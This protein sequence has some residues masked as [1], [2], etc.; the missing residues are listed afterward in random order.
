VTRLRAAL[1]IA[2]AGALVIL[3]GMFGTAG[4]LSGLGAIALGTALSAPDAPGRGRS[5]A[6]W[7]A[8]MLA[9]CALAAVGVPLALVAETPGGLLAGIGASLAVIA[10]ALG[11][12]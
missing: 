11:L 6:N 8:L 3:V 9:G 7:W 2:G 12:P 1:L 5:G 10:A 4:D